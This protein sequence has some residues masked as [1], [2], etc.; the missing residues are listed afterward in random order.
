ME[1]ATVSFSRV[2]STLVCTTSFS[3]SPGLLELRDAFQKTKHILYYA[4]LGIDKFWVLEA[5]NADPTKTEDIV[6]EKLKETYGVE[7]ARRTDVV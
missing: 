3:L 6:L 4:N 2:G 1:T 5:P 7:A